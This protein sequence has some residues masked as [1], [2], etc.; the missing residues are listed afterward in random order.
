[1]GIRMTL[2][3]G[4]GVGTF[5]LSLIIIFISPRHRI[6]GL[7]DVPNKKIPVI[8]CPICNQANPITSDERPLRLP[9]GGCGKTLLIE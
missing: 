9:C 8:D 7:D 5:V 6:D 3:L 4:A 1:M 2:V